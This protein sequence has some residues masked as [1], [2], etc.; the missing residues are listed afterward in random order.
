[1]KC[2]FEGYD[3][4]PPVLSRGERILGNNYQIRTSFHILCIPGSALLAPWNYLNNSSGFIS[5]LFRVSVR[6]LKMTGTAC[7]SKK[8][9]GWRKWLFTE[10]VN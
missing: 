1:M 5:N 7:P 10:E 2:D 8:T 4:R 3:L 6:T 9:W